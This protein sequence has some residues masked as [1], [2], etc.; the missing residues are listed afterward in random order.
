M[1]NTI[2]NQA[3]EINTIMP[4][5]EAAVAFEGAHNIYLHAHHAE[6]TSMEDYQICEKAMQDAAVRLCEAVRALSA[7]GGD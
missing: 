7:K 2:R 1:R 4:I 3:A 5:V 6:D